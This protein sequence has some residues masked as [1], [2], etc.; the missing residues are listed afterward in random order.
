[1][2]RRKRGT[3]RLGRAPWLVLGY[4]ADHPSFASIHRTAS[5]YHSV[6]SERA[7]AHASPAA[8]EARSPRPSVTAAA[9]PIRTPVSPAPTADATSHPIACARV[10]MPNS[11]TRTHAGAGTGARGGRYG[12]S[13]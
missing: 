12:E 1:M 3:E 11:P 8:A 6:A 5:Q 2:R 7:A 4:R 10:L 13:Y 9:A